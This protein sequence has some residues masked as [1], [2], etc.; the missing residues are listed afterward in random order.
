[1]LLCFAFVLVRCIIE[2]FE[3]IYYKSY[4][5]RAIYKHAKSTV[6]PWEKKVLKRAPTK[7]TPRIP[8][9][10]IKRRGFYI[11]KIR[12]FRP[13]SISTKPLVE[14]REGGYDDLD[15]IPKPIDDLIKDT[16]KNQRKN[17]FRLLKW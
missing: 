11:P 5:S 17:E 9:K 6:V 8:P 10:L 14:I 2:Y 4:I 12:S 13:R 7:N 15:V 16:I 3:D 1:M